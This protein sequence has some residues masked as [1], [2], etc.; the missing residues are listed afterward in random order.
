MSLDDTTSGGNS[1]SSTRHVAVGRIRTVELREVLLPDVLHLAAE[2]A[3]LLVNPFLAFAVALFL[4]DLVRVVHVPSPAVEALHR[5]HDLHVKLHVVRLLLA[6]HDRVVQVEVNQRLDLLLRG[7]EKRKLDVGVDDVHLLVRLGADVPQTVRVRLERPRLAPSSSSERRQHPQADEAVHAAVGQHEPLLSHERRAFG[8]FR[9]ALRHRPLQ[10]AHLLDDVVGMLRV[11]AAVRNLAEEGQ[12]RELHVRRVRAVRRDRP[13]RGGRVEVDPHERPTAILRHAH[14]LHGHDVERDEPAVDRKQ[15]GLVVAVDREHRVRA[16]R[17]GDVSH[18]LVGDEISRR[19]AFAARRHRV[20]RADEARVRLLVLLVRERGLLPSARVLVRGAAFLASG[21]RVHDDAA[22]FHARGFGLLFVRRRRLLLLLLRGVVDLV[23]DVLQRLRRRFRH[24]VRG[25]AVLRDRRGVR[26]EYRVRRGLAALLRVRVR[27]AVERDLDVVAL[28]GFNL[29]R[30]AARL[31]PE[32]HGALAELQPDRGP[33]R[34]PELR[35][36]LLAHAVRVRGDQ[37]RLRR[38]VRR[39]EVRAVHERLQRGFLRGERRRVHVLHRLRRVDHQRPR[40]VRAV[41][42]HAR[43]EGDGHHAVV[44]LLI[45]ALR[46]QLELVFAARLQDRRVADVHVLRL[47]V[48][49]PELRRLEDDVLALLRELRVRDL[50][51]VVHD[52]LDGN[53]APT[54]R[55]RRERRGFLHRRRLGGVAHAHR[56]REPGGHLDDLHALLLQSR[57][58]VRHERALLRL[59]RHRADDQASLRDEIHDLVHLRLPVLALGLD[60]HDHGDVRVREHLLR[61]G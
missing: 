26:D 21:L 10:R 28:P 40:D 8:F 57:V 44:E 13:R 59:L 27:E 50:R 51:L 18:G 61:D 31:R 41:L 2:P 22:F 36:E 37:R 45:A 30:R 60:V 15:H 25:G 42:H 52:A 4:L 17:H 48:F 32:R 34:L 29:L 53:H 55:F 11:A 43:A 54:H 3:E 39:R 5:L 49:H 46:A 24:H 7:L 1:V 47:D 38:V 23:R 16:S 58:R 33:D 20:L 19:A 6:D 35:R 14:A 9:L 56:V 12:V